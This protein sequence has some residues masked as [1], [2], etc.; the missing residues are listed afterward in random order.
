MCIGSILFHS[1]K[2]KIVRCISRSCSSKFSFS[3]IQ[4]HGNLIFFLQNWFVY[5]FMNLYVMIKFI[6]F[7]SMV[8]LCTIKRK[9]NV[10]PMQTTN[11]LI[12]TQFCKTK[13]IDHIG[14]R[15]KHYRKA[16]TAVPYNE[17]FR[18]RCVTKKCNAAQVEFY[19]NR[20]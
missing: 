6:L 2:S 5:N 8:M 16:I 1:L 10:E 15:H 11:N 17:C 4:Y 13:F 19:N 18:R 14:D 20:F 7:T 12:T 9:N 3:K